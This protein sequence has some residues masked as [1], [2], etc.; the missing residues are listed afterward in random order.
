MEKTIQ[1]NPD[2]LQSSTKR[3]KRKKKEKN[4]EHSLKANSIKKELLKKIKEHQ[5]KSKEAAI[6]KLEN[7][8]KEKEK[9]LDDEFKLSLDF[10]NT[11]S[12]EKKKKQ[13]RKRKK[14]QTQPVKK[15]NLKD[16]PPYGVLKGGKK[17]LYREYI[18]TLKNKPNN[19]NDESLKITIEDKKEAPKELTE[20]QKKILDLF[21]KSYC[22]TTFFSLF[23]M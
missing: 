3:Y 9:S 10:L 11:V 22:I 12:K 17:P 18:K 2:F 1:I 23:K 20:R 7:N 19:S 5:I 8:E 14:A 13:R 4:K 16:D 15:Y 21:C 6:Q